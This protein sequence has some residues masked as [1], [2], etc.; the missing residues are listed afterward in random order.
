MKK[1]LRYW[2]SGMLLAMLVFSACKPD[3]N[4]PVITADPATVN[5][6]FDLKWGTSSFDLNQYYPGPDGRRYMIETLQYYVSDVCLIKPNDSATLVKK[7][8]LV[9]MYQPATST[10]L[11]GEVPAGSYDRI[12]FNLGLDSALNHSDPSS[13]AIN[14]PM[15]TANGMFWSWSTQYIFSKVEGRADT[16]GGHVENAFLWH[17]GLDS[18]MQSLEFGNLNLTLAEGQT[19]T[20]TLTLD[21]EK[22][23]F[24]A[25]DTLDVAVDVL[26]HT[27]DNV[28]LARRVIRNLKGSISH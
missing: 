21:V 10:L 11:S 18:L 4:P 2:F 22:I 25:T 16:T 28:A 8:A 13:Y 17:S 5:L 6:Q 12:S 15:S 24:G 7:V 26:T 3:P 20:I 23:I 14:H 27:L 19:S 1:S 9:D